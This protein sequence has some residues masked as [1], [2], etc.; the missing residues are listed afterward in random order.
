MV[1]WY[2]DHDRAEPRNFHFEKS[3]LKRHI[4]RIPAGRTPVDAG[5]LFI[6]QL[7]AN[8]LGMIQKI[9]EEMGFVPLRALPA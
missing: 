2:L 6:A 7:Q 4:R 9:H 5:F 8:T 3:I 1:S